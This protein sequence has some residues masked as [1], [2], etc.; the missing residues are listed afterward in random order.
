MICY[1]TSEN[2]GTG[3]KSMFWRFSKRRFPN[4]ILEQSPDGKNIPRQEHQKILSLLYKRSRRELGWP[5]Q[6]EEIPFWKVPFPR[7][8]Y[9]TGRDDLLEQLNRDRFIQEARTGLAPDILT[10]MPGIGK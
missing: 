5:E 9:F 7:N 2:G 10:G 6:P 1:D 3:H 4:W 8:A